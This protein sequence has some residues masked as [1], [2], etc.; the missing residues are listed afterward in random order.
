MILSR[1]VKQYLKSV[2]KSLPCSMAE[3]SA[4]IYDLK[5]NILAADTDQ[6]WTVESLEERFGTSDEI[7]DGF[8]S[9]DLPKELNKKVS[10]F[11]VINRIILSVCILLI[12]L[13]LCAFVYSHLTRSANTSITNSKNSTMTI[14]GVLI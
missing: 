8:C 3:K 6:E 1:S 4:I 7:A 5:Q 13:L 12:C 9:G 14:N 10:K 2:R 11:K